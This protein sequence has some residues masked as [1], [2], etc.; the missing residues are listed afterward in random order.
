MSDEYSTYVYFDIYIYVDFNE[1]WDVRFVLIRIL[2][3]YYLTKTY[4]HS[5]IVLFVGSEIIANLLKM[6]ILEEDD[7]LAYGITPDEEEKIVDGRPTWMKT[8]HTS[9][10]TWMT[11]V[12]KVTCTLMWW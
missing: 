9:V 11:L 10:S 12:P 2:D 4:W 5:W 6:Q 8:L 1:A 3:Y 7:D